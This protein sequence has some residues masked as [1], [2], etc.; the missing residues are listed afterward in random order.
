[1][2]QRTLGADACVGAVG[3]GC[4]GM[5][6]AYG[7]S[8]DEESVATLHGALDAGITFIDTADH[9]GMGRNEALIGQALRPA[10]RDRAVVSVKFGALVGVSRPRRIAETVDAASLQSTEDDLDAIEQAVPRG[11]VAGERYAPTLLALLDS[12]RTGS[13]H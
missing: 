11:A 12:E 13:K 4:A 9:Y 8:A 5:P 6:G 2:E 7:H 10:A 3:L 1:M